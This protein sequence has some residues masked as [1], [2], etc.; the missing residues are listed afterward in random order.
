M[1]VIRLLRTGKKNQPTYKIVVTDKDNPPRGGRFVE[2]VG[3]YNPKTK[4]KTLNKERIQYWVS[5]GVQPSDTVYNMLVSEKVVEGKKRPSHKKSK[6]EAPAAE[7]E[8]GAP[9][10]EK[11]AEQPAAA[12]AEEKPA[13]TPV[14]EEKTAEPAPAVKEEKEEAPVE[15]VQDQKAEESGNEE[16]VK[17]EIKGEPDKE[18][19]PE[20]Q[21]EQKPEEEKTAD[22]A[23]QTEPE[24]EEQ[25]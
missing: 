18:P 14:T 9:E 15:P 2:E 5:K 24:K 23:A 7:A 8:A 17:E 3:F 11:P 25:K 20:T 16:A 12:P 19:A 1:L 10:G 21:I 4:E 6:K 13:E 22:P